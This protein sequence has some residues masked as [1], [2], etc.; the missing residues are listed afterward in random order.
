LEVITYVVEITNVI[1]TKSD[2][3]TNKHKLT[4]TLC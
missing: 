2:K 1:K 4:Q 3:N